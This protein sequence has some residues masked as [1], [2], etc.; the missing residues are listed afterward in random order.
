MAGNEDGEV[1]LVDARGNRMARSLIAYD[2]TEGQT[3]K[4]AQYI[5]DGVRSAGHDAQVLD[6]RRPP[7]GFS[8]EGFDAILIGASIHL[9]K[10]SRHLSAFVRRHKARLVA[11]PTAFFSV[12][13]SAA[14]NEKQKADAER[15]L[16]EFLQ[17][18]DWSPTIKATFAGG[19]MYREYGFLK[20]WMMKRIAR[21]AGKDTDPSK[22]HEYTDW[23][24]VDG[25][26]R[27]FLVQIDQQQP[28]G[29]T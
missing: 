13:L 9:G 17:Q 15:C 7:S 8:L 12:S 11:M 23:Q 28:T 18:M 16:N 22:N 24:A 19:L 6:I 21:D 1:S 4:I 25:F 27:A 14:G 2:T 20:R 26:V 10:H 5:G 29:R 3:R